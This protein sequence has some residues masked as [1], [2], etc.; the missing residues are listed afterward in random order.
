[1]FLV[2]NNGEYHAMPG[3]MA[4]ITND[5]D[6][7]VVTMQRGSVAKDTWVPSP[8]QMS[9]YTLLPQKQ[10]AR[11]EEIREVALLS[12]VADNFFWFGRYL[13]RLDALCRLLRQVANRMIDERAYDTPEE[14]QLLLPFLEYRLGFEM[15]E[16]PNPSGNES[17]QVIWKHFSDASY[18][19][20]LPSL[21]RSINYT[22]ELLRPRLAD[23]MWRTINRLHDHI[24]QEDFST[25]WT[26]QQILDLLNR[27]LTSVAAVTGFESEAMTRSQGWRFLDIGRRLERAAW[28]STLIRTV[29]ASAIGKRAQSRFGLTV[30]LDLLLELCDSFMTYRTRYMTLPDF[31]LVTDLLVKDHTNP[32]SVAYQLQSLAIHCRRLPGEATFSREMYDWVSDVADGLEQV[33]IADLH[34]ADEQSFRQLEAILVETERRLPDISDKLTLRY[35]AHSISQT[36][37]QKAQR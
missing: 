15:P 31:A 20:S 2:W 33:D 17:G 9:Y 4:R 27:C 1:V 26:P 7:P 36:S 22:A 23:D 21:I 24:G 3:G 29:S 5:P 18:S 10:T 37:M 28:Y 19:D 34:E 12:R 25:D 6:S 35:F 13:E 16:D 8:G 11:R 32:R 14:I 30:A